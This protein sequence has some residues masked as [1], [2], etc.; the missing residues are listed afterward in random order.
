VFKEIS[1]PSTL[2]LNSPVLQ[3][4]AGYRELLRVWLMFD[5]AAKLVWHGG[6]DIYS[7]NKKDVAVLYE[8]WLFFKLLDIV[9][10]V[11]KIETLATDNLI[12]KTKDGLGLKLKQGKYLPV[13]GIYVSDTR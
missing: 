1:N 3:R 11:F 6:D 2:P 7:G 9:K 4:K 10:D 13:K 5:L 12:E 8:Y